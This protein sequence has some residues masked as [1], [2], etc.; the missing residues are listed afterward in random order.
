MDNNSGNNV[1]NITVMK[2]ILIG[3][4]ILSS[5]QQL[6]AQ[7]KRIYLALDD[8][9]DY[10]WA[11]DEEKY[12]NAFLET[13]D[14]YIRLNDST[15]KSP[16]PYQN[17]WNCDGSFW[18]YTYEKNRSS[19]QFNKLIDQVRKEKITFPLNPLVGLYGP[20]PTEAT[21]RGMYYAGTLERRYGLDLKLAYIM[22]DQVMPLGLSSLWAGSGAKYS[23]H[24]VCACATKVKGMK[25]NG[26]VRPHEIYW[27]KG[28][29]DQ[30]VLMKWNTISW[31][32]M[33]LGGYAEAAI[34]ADAVKQ[35]IELM[36][37]KNRYPYHIA[38]AFGVG[39]D[40]LKTLT[41]KYVTEAKNLSDKDHQVIVSNEIDFFEDFEKAYG[42][43]L[44]SETISYGT[45]EW[46][47]SIA[48]LADAS[49]SIKRSIE[50]LRAAEA[51]YTYVALKDK[52]F[53]NDLARVRMNAWFACGLY[54]EHDWTCDG[55]IT[56]HDKALWQKKI[57][58]QLKSYVDTL[59]SR[60]LEKLGS[61]I[62]K[63]VGSNEL[64]YI[65]NPLGWTRTDY[66]DYPYYG[67]SD[68]HIIDKTTLKE[69]PFQFVYVKNKPYL[70]I[71]ASE[72]PSV[73][74]KV[75]EIAPG[76]GSLKIEN[77]GYCIYFLNF[78][79]TPLYKVTFMPD[80]SLKSLID[81]TN[82]NTECVKQ[83]NGLYMNDMVPGDETKG[84]EM[85][86]ENDGPVSLT[87]VT[88][89]D[90]PVKHTSKLTLFRNIER[91]EIENY[92]TQNFGDTPISY[93]F[94]P[95][96]SQPEIWHE[97]AGAILKAKPQSKGGHYAEIF[98]RLDWLG[99][100]HF[101]DI[102]EKNSGITIS[103]RDAYFMKIGDSKTD[104]LDD[105]SPQVNI[106]AG[107]RID[108][109]RNLGLPNQ[110]G[111]SYFENYIALKPHQ[112]PF[113]ATLAMKF[114]LEHQN[115][116]IAAKITGTSE[117]YPASNYSLFNISDPNVLVWALKPSEEGVDKG[118]V[119]RVWNTSNENKICSISSVNP[120]ESCK[121]ITHIETDISVITPEFGKI[122]TTIG[123][124]R[125]QTFRM[126]LGQ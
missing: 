77:A 22:E 63:P 114:S 50:K 44:P 97:E 124:N 96:V 42:K 94:S 23:W 43:L 1:S 34:P 82:N 113:D 48:S 99:I 15:A 24:G 123:H 60:S 40:N 30:M 47:I 16:Y 33:H 41:N 55:P 25:T 17:K 64:I 9:T 62:F 120:I 107:G 45:T 101:A 19:E 78:A 56:K 54:F 11:D 90:Y 87:L 73:G 35:C 51:L 27:Y 31:D 68:I 118:I 52:N 115:P 105:S 58:N 111:D 46:G 8:H 12:K 116:F 13:L 69:V 39:W 18:I 119:L 38:G 29:D 83:V 71:L 36:S 103:N 102:S 14:F 72:V 93:S 20:A 74:Y 84:M 4:V 59:Y 117:Q 21:L 79:E 89:S 100:N 109:D 85:K 10:M 126:F 98:N 75:Y 61:Y 104:S 3:F 32:N 121:S 70:R 92:I 95:N 122:N 110:D 6:N 91:I 5:L 86:V 108:A 80:G 106:L 53:C 26:I 57:A 66:C 7:E 28:L 49:A 65:F 67:P 125:I 2:N 76:P 112:G 81:K 37:D 88:Q